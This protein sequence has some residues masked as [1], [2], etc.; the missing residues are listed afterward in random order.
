MKRIKQ[1]FL[2]VFCL[3]FLFTASSC[4][5][6]PGNYEETAS[7]STNKTEQFETVS[8]KEAEEIVENLHI[9]K[10]LHPSLRNLNIKE[11]LKYN[12]APIHPGAMRYYVDNGLLN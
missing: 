1:I 2:P 11:M 10:T 9:L 12:T 8:Q 6:I 4:G 3:I 5:S 7:D